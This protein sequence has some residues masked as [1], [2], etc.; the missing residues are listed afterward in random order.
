MDF[1]RKLRFCNDP[2]ASWVLDCIHFGGRY[3][4][5]FQSGLF[6]GDVKF[7]GRNMSSAISNPSVVDKYFKKELDRGS[8]TGPFS[9]DLINGLHSNCFGLGP[10]P[11]ENDN[12]LVFLKGQQRQ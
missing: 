2:R 1:E 4:L 3:S 9:D 6:F 12:S 11:V 10:Y 5:W 8:N 7:S